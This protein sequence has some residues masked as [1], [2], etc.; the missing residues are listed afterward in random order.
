MAETTIMRARYDDFDAFKEALGMLKDSGLKDYQAYAPVDLQELEHLM[1]SKGSSVRIWATVGAVLGMFAF[2]F[3]CVA[4]SLIYKIVVGG[5]PPWSNVPFVV[6]A[7]EGTILIGSISAFFAV[8]ILARLSPRK[9]PPEYGP[10]FSSDSFGI[11][12]RVE[13]GRQKQVS[14]LLKETR[15]VE[16]N[17]LEQR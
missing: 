14:N 2:W 10:R 15:A 12:V 7:Y 5:K 1:P 16:I 6:I 17:E 3:M 9:P 13:P 8:L 11:E 4:S